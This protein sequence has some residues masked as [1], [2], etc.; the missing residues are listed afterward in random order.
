MET[1]SDDQAVTWGEGG[2]RSCMERLGMLL[3]NM[4]SAPKEDHSGYMYCFCSV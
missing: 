2:G 3:K 4:K 1:L